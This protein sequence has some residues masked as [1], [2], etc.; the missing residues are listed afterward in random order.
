MATTT[1]TGDE[2]RAAV[3]ELTGVLRLHGLEYPVQIFCENKQVD[4]LCGTRQSM[5]RHRPS[6][7]NG[8][9]DS[10]GIQGFRD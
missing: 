9:L 6:A 4:V 2:L 8:I 10:C 5:N 7:A 1:L 3:P